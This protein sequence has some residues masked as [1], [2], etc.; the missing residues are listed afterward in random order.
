MPHK[1]IV[2]CLLMAALAFPARASSLWHPEPGFLPEDARHAVP[3]NPAPPERT[4]PKHAL[5]PLSAEGEGTIRC[6]AAKE[7]VAAL[8]F[9]LC[10]LATMTTG[11]DADIIDFLREKRI[12]ATLFMGGKWM[13]SHRERSMQ[14][15]ADPLFEIGNHGWSHGNFG[16]MGEKAM[17]EQIRWTQAEYELL[18][19]EILRRAVTEGRGVE[20]P[21]AI[22]LFRLPYGRCSDKALALLAREGLEV[23]QWSVVAETPQDN[24]VRGM[25]ERVAGQVRPG[26]IILF[27]ANRV[28]KGSA[29]M[30]KET[31]EALQRKGYRFV[32]VGELLTLGEPQRTRDGYFNKPGDNLSLDKHFGID[33]TGRRK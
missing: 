29:F 17:L 3:N 23:I 30:L 21:E 25:G 8:T 4:V 26:A 24:A 9:D 1:L 33:G 12:P 11:Y 5:P 13:R 6:V 15:M 20:L 31:V 16:I 22:R 10:E 27:H 2:C 19:E 28:P 7:K 18:R 14:L 32:T